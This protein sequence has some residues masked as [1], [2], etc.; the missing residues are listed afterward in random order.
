MGIRLR[1]KQFVILA[2]IVCAVLSLTSCGKQEEAELAEKTIAYLYM[3]E[4]IGVSEIS[5]LKKL[6]DMG[7]YNVKS[8]YGE[9]SEYEKGFVYRQSIP[10]NSTVGTDFEIIL[11]VSD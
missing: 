6:E 1:I 9:S 2:I 7:F 3:P 5:A 11:Y 4:L 10:A 8:E